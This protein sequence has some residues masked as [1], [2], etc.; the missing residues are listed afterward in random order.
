MIV[1]SWDSVRADRRRM[2]MSSPHLDSARRDS[3]VT[4]KAGFA[5]CAVAS[6]THAQRLAPARFL[7]RLSATSQR[8]WPCSVGRPASR[9]IPRLRSLHSTNSFVELQ[10]RF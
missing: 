4:S 1:E 8:R 3:C 5:P 10:R 7:T 2:Y 6:S 9:P